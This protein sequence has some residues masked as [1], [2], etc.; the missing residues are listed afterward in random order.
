MDDI[1]YLK[2]NEIN[3]EMWDA[4]VINSSNG[5][6][7]ARSWYLDAMSPDWEALVHKDY[8]V[9]MPLTVSKKMGVSYLSQPSFSQQLGIIGPM[10]FPDEVVQKFIRF[11]SSK[12]SLVEINLNYKN[13]FIGGE[14]KCNLILDLGQSFEN[15]KSGFRPDLI[16][17]AIKAK[18]ILKETTDYKEVIHLF[19]KFYGNRVS[20]LKQKH[21]DRLSKICEHLKKMSNLIVKR[22][23]TREGSLLASA[24]FF[25]DE[26]RIYYIMSATLPEG[27]KLD[28]NAFLLYEMIK[29]YSESKYIFD[30]EGSSIPSI[31]FFFK[32][33]NPVEE[34][35]P[36]VR[37]DNLHPLIKKVKS[38]IS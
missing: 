32:K 11:G 22:V 35:Y 25:R 13:E 28:A 29:E 5:L 30:F 12:F 21:F 4:C 24:L 20:H 18:L 33:F 15:I 16:N 34:N 10:D 17:K 37:I 27:R 3:K 1:R 26:K 36:V 31:N 9:V 23:V 7:Y 6:I 2:H 19:R 14:E 38:I 8:I